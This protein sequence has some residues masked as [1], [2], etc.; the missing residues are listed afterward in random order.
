MVRVPAQY[1]GCLVDLVQ[2]FIRNDDYTT[3]GIEEMIEQYGHLKKRINGIKIQGDAPN[4]WWDLN[5]EQF[6]AIHCFIFEVLG[7]YH[8]RSHNTFY[9]EEHHGPYDVNGKE[10]HAFIDVGFPNFTLQL[11]GGKRRNVMVFVLPEH[12]GAKF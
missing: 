9:S 5:P 12:G 10:Y 1:P 7:P 11:K 8:A 3:E 4:E 6:Q 2:K